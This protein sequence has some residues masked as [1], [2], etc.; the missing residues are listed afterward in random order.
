MAEIQGVR[1]CSPT[2]PAARPGLPGLPG[3]L[4]ACLAAACAGP[5]TR[6]SAPDGPTLATLTLVL[7]P[8]GPAHE[9]LRALVGEFEVDCLWWPTAGADPIASRG[10][11]R[12]YWDPTAGMVVAKFGGALPEGFFPCQTRVGWDAV[13]GCYVSDWWS[14]AGNLLLPLADGHVQPAGE[15]VFTRGTSTASSIQVL[16]VLGDDEHRIE[17]SHRTGTPGSAPHP[18]LHLRCRRHEP[19]P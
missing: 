3:I 10:K 14:G 5:T 11:L 7:G 12:A 4:A 6:G 9:T 19:V 16:T 13:R 18:L 2:H 15:L 1:A 8:S 17:L